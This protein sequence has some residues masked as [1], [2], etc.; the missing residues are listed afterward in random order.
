MKLSKL[1]LIC[2]LLLM[3]TGC[4]TQPTPF[5]SPLPVSTDSTQTIAMTSPVNTPPS[6]IV[7]QEQAS[8]DEELVPD[9]DTGI[10][11]GVIERVKHDLPLAEW[12]LYLGHI[13][14]ADDDITFEVARMSPAEDPYAHLSLEDGV[15][16]FK[17]IQPGKYALYTTNPR[18][19]AILLVNLDTGMDVIFEVQAGKVL[20]LGIVPVDFGF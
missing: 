20:D 13:I 7:G 2:S 5:V 16:I 14:H 10:V 4:K 17:G 9:A 8:Y 12:N 1:L 15:F 19:E 18:G 3:V 11:T 6:D